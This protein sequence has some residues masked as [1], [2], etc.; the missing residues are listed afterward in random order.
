[1]A[2]AGR[3]SK[4]KA[5]QQNGGSAASIISDRDRLG[6]VQSLVGIL[7]SILGGLDELICKHWNLEPCQHRCIIT[8]ANNH[9]PCRQLGAT[10]VPRR[11]LRSHS[12]HVDEPERGADRADDAARRPSDR[13][14]GAARRHQGE[15]AHVARQRLMPVDGGRMAARRRRRH[16]AAVAAGGRHRRW[17]TVAGRVAP[18]LYILYGRQRMHQQ[19]RQQHYQHHLLRGL[20]AQLDRSIRRCGR[21]VVIEPSRMNRIKNNTQTHTTNHC[22]V[23]ISFSFSHSPFL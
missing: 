7:Q 4:Q 8:K 14:S 15:V 23:P 2:K 20:R 17:T 5:E 11:P 13:R 12:R 6:A 10:A 3:K 22:A 19:R 16:K 18:L 1:M 9:K 21:L